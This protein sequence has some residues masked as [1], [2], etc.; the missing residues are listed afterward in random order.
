MNC[1]KSRKRY[2]ER[3]SKEELEKRIAEE[4]ELYEKMTD[5]EKEQYNK[6]KKEDQ[7]RGE[8][9]LR[10]LQSIRTLPPYGKV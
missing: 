10:L 9:Y 4:K 5:E 3:K 1:L 2:D 8:R 6:R 7:E